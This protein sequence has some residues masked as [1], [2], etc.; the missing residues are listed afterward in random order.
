MTTPALLQ[1]TML[2]CL[3]ELPHNFRVDDI[4]AFHGRDSA[5][6]AEYTDARTLMK[7]LTWGGHAACL[8]IRFHARHADV[9][10][11]ID[12]SPIDSAPLDGMRPNA[13]SD[14]HETAELRR[15]AVR[16]LGLTQQID[17]FERAYRA[18]PQ[19][20]PLIAGHP[21]LRVPLTTTPFEALAWAITGQQISLGVAI[22]LRRK[23]IL[24]ASVRHSSGLACHPDAQR[25][26]R[27]TEADLRQAGFSQA[28]AQ[29]LMNLSHLISE[30]R[31]PLDAWVD[32][33]PVDTIREQLLAIRGIGPWT[34][35]YTL[36]RGF[37]WL[38]G[39]LHGDAAVRRS[40]Q[41][42]LGCTEKLTIEQT[43]QWLAPFSPWRAL[44]AAHLWAAFN[45]RAA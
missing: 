1:N 22:S 14:A 16:M 6:I 13:S 40:L 7:G 32:A 21:G 26:S 5:Q 15:I 9:E 45:I 27:L 37:G 28:K 44:V 18:H 33:P 25:L 38:D 3:V 17:D 23:M 43:K 36:L 29:T 34:V 41:A 30:H 8:T 12:K 35:E 39:S 20:G 42:L 31:L 2:S 19:L 4:L 24:A 11:I 10:L